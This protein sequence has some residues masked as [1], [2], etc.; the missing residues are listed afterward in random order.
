MAIL[1]NPVFTALW[2]AFTGLG[3]EPLG[4]PPNFLP[5]QQAGR[6]YSLN[7]DAQADGSEA[8]PY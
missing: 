8:W 1:Q 6:P 2:A 5:A 7:L 3:K 4:W